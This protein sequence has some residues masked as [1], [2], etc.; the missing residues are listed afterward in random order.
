M[1]GK[2][3]EEGAKCDLC[4]KFQLFRHR[5]SPAFISRAF[6]HDL[7]YYRKIGTLPTGYYS[8]AAFLRIIWYILANL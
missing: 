5:I 2:D 1:G 7:H 3:S 4:V 8:I 6:L